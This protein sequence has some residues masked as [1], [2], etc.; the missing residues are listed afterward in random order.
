MRSSFARRLVADFWQRVG[1]EEAFPRQ[2]ELQ[3]MSIAP[4]SIRKVLHQRLNTAYIQHRLERRGISLRTRWNDRLLNGC[5]VA[6]KGEAV[7]FVNGTL[8]PDQIR[9]VIG[10]EFGHYLAEYEFPRA[11][12]LRYLGEGIID[13]LDGLRPATA[14]ERLAAA[15]ADV[16]IGAYVHYMD[17]DGDSRSTLLVHHVEHTANIVCA[18]LLAPIDV[19]LNQISEAG[20]SHNP[21]LIVEILEMRFGLPTGYAESYAERLLRNLRQ[22]QSFSEI[23]GL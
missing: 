6:F 23:L 9:I 4:V 14:N 18:E 15:L 17:R 11:R 13:V 8:S 12:A 1:C 5:L 16:P 10:H 20:A 21:A 19:V 22:R 2:L 3:I 7:I